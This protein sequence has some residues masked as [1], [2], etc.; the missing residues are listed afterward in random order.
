M[1][2]RMPQEAFLLPTD[3]SWTPAPSIYGSRETDCAALEASLV[4]VGY[5]AQRLTVADFALASVLN[6]AELAGLT[7]G[8]FPRIR[9]W[10]Q[11]MLARD[12]L[13]RALEDVRHSLQG[14]C[15]PGVNLK[16]GSA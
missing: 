5:V 4:H 1:K 11:R 15:G 8:E 10:L 7:L 14:I 6:S 12:S 13:K 2:R 3:D 16:G 9:E